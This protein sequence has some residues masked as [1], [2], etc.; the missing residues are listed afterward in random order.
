MPSISISISI[1]ISTSIPI[2]IST[3]TLAHLHH[4][5]IK[6]RAGASRYWHERDFR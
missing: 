5:I 3:S 6:G 4:R 2:L 1:L